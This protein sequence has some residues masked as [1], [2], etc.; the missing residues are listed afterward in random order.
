MADKTPSL[1]D[2][3]VM[4]A[5]KLQ[6]VDMALMGK[7]AGQIATAMRLTKNQVLETL[8]EALADAHQILLEKTERLHLILLIRMERMTDAGMP[9]ALGFVDPETGLP[10]DK[11]GNPI[12]KQMRAPDRAWVR[13]MANM[14]KLTMEW[15]DRL[16]ERRAKMPEN[17]PDAIRQTMTGSD[18]MYEF[19]R[20]DIQAAWVS[21]NADLQA[22]D[23]IP[24]R[25]TN[26]DVDRVDGSTEPELEFAR[27]KVEKKID[28]LLAVTGELHDDEGDDDGD[29]D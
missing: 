9:Y 28:K 15:E 24:S 7:S 19:A 17:L 6:M 4:S 25:T 3:L 23:L 29:G 20:E 21:E 5:R 12:T 14:A 13:E 2:Q 10:F 18:E 11:D 26:A 1:T 16:Y 22:I 8:D 27:K